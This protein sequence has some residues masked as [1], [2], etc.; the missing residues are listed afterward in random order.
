MRELS[1]KTLIAVPERGG[2]RHRCSMKDHS[3]PR[4][5]L[6][7][8]HSAPALRFDR[9]RSLQ[10]IRAGVYVDRAAWVGLAPWERYALRVEAVAATW[11]APVFC[12]ESAAHVH[13]LPLFGE[14]KWIHLLDAGGT[15][16]R[17]GDVVVH[18]TRDARSVESI[19]GMLVTPV[20]DTAL[21][22]CRV[23][24]PAFALA[25]A[26]RAAR[27]SDPFGSFAVRGREQ[28]SRRGIRQLDWIDDN[29][30]PA[31]ES[32][33]ESVSRAVIGWL[34]YERPELQVRHRYEGVEDRVDFQFPS[35]RAVGESDGYGKYD[36]EDVEA[37]KRRF[38]EEKRRED[39]LRRNG[40]PFARWDWGDA[41]AITPLDRA[42]RAAGLVSL[43]PRD[44]RRLATL[45]RNTRSLA[46][47]TPH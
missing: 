12:L 13:G 10:R 38:I 8:E 40:H 16:W 17:E 31:A 1:T 9:D 14:P 41:M 37:T 42:L 11:T 15:T 47:P 35:T 2:C 4:L 32:P 24:P 6:A 34:G 3:L 26:D 39:R 20:G 18:G 22:L 5:L 44:E 28:V 45:I 7:R 23:L 46:R 21:D 43:Y 27:M 33:G 30:D 25:V 29:V 36:A 19:D